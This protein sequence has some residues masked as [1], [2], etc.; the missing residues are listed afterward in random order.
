MELS[1]EQQV[2]Q[3]KEEYTRKI[4]EVQNQDSSATPEVQEHKAVSQVTEGLIQEQVPHFQASS[5]EPGRPS[6][7]SPEIQDKAQEMINMIWSKGPYESIKAV[8][9]A[10]DPA[11]TD[12]YHRAVTGKEIWH[13]LVKEGKIPEVQ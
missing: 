10:N 1:K 6:A 5:H 3:L 8:Q 2:Q 13:A 7:A 12:E 11:L 4:E 9:E